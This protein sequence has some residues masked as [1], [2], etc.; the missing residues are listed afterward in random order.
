MPPGP[1]LA[2]IAAS[3]SDTRTGTHVKWIRRLG[4]ST[5]GFRYVD[6]AGRPVRA[7]RALARIDALRI[8]PAWRDVH[9]AKSPTAAIQAWG[10]DARGRKQYRY[11]ARAVERGELRKFYRVRQLAKDLP[12]IR[13]SLARD[14]RAREPSR[15]AVAAA[16]VRLIGE[17]FFRPGSERYTKENR[18]FGITT[19]RKSHVSVEGD[20]VYF[21]YVGKSRVRQSQCVPNRDLAHLVSRHLR[22]PGPRLFRFRAGRRWF[23][24]SSRDVNEYL[25]D[26]LGAAFSAK[27]FRTWGGT[28]R[29]ATVLAE[30]GPGSSSTQ[31]RRNVATAMRLVA[32]ELGNTPT[33]C[34]KS[35]VHPIVLAK[36]LDDG[37]TIDLPARRSRR[38]KGIAHSPEERAL[39]AF[40]DA[41]F[42]E[43]RTRRTRRPAVERRSLRAG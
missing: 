24:L 16:V 1:L 9:V 41:H 35:Y 12:A 28:L 37:E 27:D 4:T 3:M 18:T 32:A 5:S 2:R 14:A 33:I 20:C 7:A 39:I 22:S 8:P 17:A 15:T 25:R 29:A 21:R 42:P 36:Y 19:L 10:I 13:G 6:D 30:L 34:R 23:D 26:H 43:R 38:S 11:H 31:A 40:L